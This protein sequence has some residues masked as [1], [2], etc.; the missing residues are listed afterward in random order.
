[1]VRTK[2]PEAAGRSSGIFPHQTKQRGEIRLKDVKYIMEHLYDITKR[3]MMQANA[4]DSL[5]SKDV[6]LM[7]AEHELGSF[8]V[9]TAAQFKNID[10]L[11]AAFLGILARCPDPI[12][13][14]WHKE[15]KM[16]PAPQY[17]SELFRILINTPEFFERGSKVYNVPSHLKTEST[18]IPPTPKRERIRVLRFLYMRIYLKLPKFIRKAAKKAYRKIRG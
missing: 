2:K 12:I 11:N 8:D 18:A 5:F 15:N 13:L 17:Q 9:V 1:M 10:F 3:N 14:D 6:M 7:F 4:T 16:L